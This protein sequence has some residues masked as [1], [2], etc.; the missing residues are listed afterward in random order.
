MS[1]FNSLLREAEGLKPLMR[2][3]C[4]LAVKFTLTEAQQERMQEILNAAEDNPLLAFLLNEAD[5]VVGHELNLIS[6]DF[7]EEQQRKLEKKLDAAMEDIEVEQLWKA[8]EVANCDR[9]A[10]EQLSQVCS[11]ELQRILRQ[12]GL[13]RGKIDGVCGPFT[14]EAFTKSRQNEVISP[15]IR[16]LIPPKSTSKLQVNVLGQSS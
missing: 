13:Y 4:A 1:D 15:N 5:H 12:R 8:I 9:Q 7:V 6:S 3:Y 16:E 11:E 2:E 14:V 10:S